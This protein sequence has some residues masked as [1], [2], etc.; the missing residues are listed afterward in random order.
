MQ[1]NTLTIRT[2]GPRRPSKWIWLGLAL[3]ATV[4]LMKPF[5]AGQG[6][7]PI[8][9]ASV[10]A[11]SLDRP[12]AWLYE[13]KRNYTAVKDYSCFLLTQENVKGKLQKENIIHFKMRTQPFSV[14]MNWRAPDEL[15]GREVAFVAG[16]NN[17]KMR[18]KD[19]KIGGFFGFQSIDVNDPRVLQNSR[20]TITEA[21]I[22][23][24]IEQN[25]KHWELA[26][27]MG[28]TKAVIADRAYSCN[29]RECLRVEVTALGRSSEAYCYRTVIFLEKDS[30]IPIRMENYDWPRE[31]GSPAGDLL[32]LYSY[33]QL[34]FNIG[35]RDADFDK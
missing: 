29:G 32:E 33:S 9:Q 6:T 2:T 31:R 19:N 14:Y 30:K 22:G 16:K 13:A 25:L 28:K 12:I 27:K 17:N 26:K 1:D 15:K 24:M 35:L 8:V 23:N 21:G 18:V 20:H 5:A 10:D 4:A 3:L 34:Q 11:A 7:G